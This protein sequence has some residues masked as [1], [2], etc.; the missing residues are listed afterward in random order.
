MTQPS[1]LYSSYYIRIRK[2]AYEEEQVGQSIYKHMKKSKFFF[3]FEQK[4]QK[5]KT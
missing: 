3:V 2:L 5:T 4:K 1:Q